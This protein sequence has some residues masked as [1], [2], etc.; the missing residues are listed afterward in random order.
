MTQKSLSD[1][2]KDK[3]DHIFELEG[4]GAVIEVRALNYE[5]SLSLQEEAG[6]K[7]RLKK[8]VTL[9]KSGEHETYVFHITKK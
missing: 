2:L 6:E 5:E 1:T 3:I 9:S 8:T 7:Y 4:P